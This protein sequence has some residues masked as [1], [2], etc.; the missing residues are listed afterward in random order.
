MLHSKA[1]SVSLLLLF[2]TTTGCSFF[3]FVDN[4]SPEEI[5]KSQTSKDALWNQTKALESE[6]AAY[7]K[8]LADQ[9]AEIDRMAKELSDQQIKTA[10]AD[11]RVAELNKSVD[12][13]N[14]Q[15]RQ[16]QEDRQK[17]QPLQET[18]LVQL[19]TEPVREDKTVQAPAQ[20]VRKE[21]AEMKTP[22]QKALTIKV[23]A[24]DGNIAS[25]RALSKRLGKMGYRVTLIDQAPRSDFK[26]DTIFYRPGL[27]T[28][29]GTMAKKL[30]GG[31][32]TRPLT[33]SSGFD[34][35]V[36]TGRQP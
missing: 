1:I 23:L 21:P 19:K 3:R 17:E 20:I 28:A 36:V 2:L 11:K 6:K 18:E 10:R 27:Q 34:I 15:M 8:K 22:E 16:R 13:L 4:S 29:A 12:D 9:Q 7:Q 24:G 35:I 30:G 32:A 31:A 25:A 33:W 26:V 14:A 5:Q